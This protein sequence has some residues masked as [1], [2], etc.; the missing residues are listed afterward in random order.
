[1]P[2]YE[3]MVYGMSIKTQTNTYTRNEIEYEPFT[4]NINFNNMLPWAFLSGHFA[5][6]YSA[7]QS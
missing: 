3:Y 7:L 1:M 4:Y 5:T 2:V 6:L